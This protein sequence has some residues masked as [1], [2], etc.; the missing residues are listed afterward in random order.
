LVDEAWVLT[1]AHCVD[2]ASPEQIEVIVGIHDLTANEGERIALSQIIMHP[3]YTSFGYDFDVALLR[4]AKPAQLTNTVKTIGLIGSGDQSL[5]GPG[6]IATVTGWGTRA[7]GVADYPDVLYEVGVAIVSNQV[8]NAAYEPSYYPGVI[9]Q[10]MICAGFAEGGKDS[11]QG[12][13]GG[14]LVVPDGQNG[15]L[16][17][18]IVSWGIGCGEPGLPGVYARVSALH[19]WIM[20]PGSHTIAPPAYYLVTD[21]S[22]RVGRSAQGVPA[23]NTVIGLWNRLHMP[24][25]VR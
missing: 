10:N 25:I 13:S 5:H 3:S 7:F 1:A 14:P 20:G 22:G 18:G 6:I 19:N 16:Q 15:W 11:C 8:C 17:V 4:L 21:G 9:T 12:D 2:G 23:N 24:V